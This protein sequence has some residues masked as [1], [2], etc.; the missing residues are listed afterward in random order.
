M[1]LS[2]ADSRNFWQLSPENTP[3]F[4]LLLGF[5]DQQFGSHPGGGDP[6]E[7]DLVHL[8]LP[9]LHSP[10]PLAPLTSCVTPRVS[11]LQEGIRTCKFRQEIGLSKDLPTPHTQTHTHQQAPHSTPSQTLLLL[12]SVPPTHLRLLVERLQYFK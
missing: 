6:T 8:C 5:R 9:L 3:G 2:R 12:L 10:V 4:L 7:T 11:T 1:P